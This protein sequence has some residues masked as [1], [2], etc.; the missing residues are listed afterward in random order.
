M[1]G[2]HCSLDGTGIRESGI[3]AGALDLRV[4]MRTI[5]T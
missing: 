1:S 2:L 4:L 3:V 5:Y